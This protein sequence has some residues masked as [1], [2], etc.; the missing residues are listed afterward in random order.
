MRPVLVDDQVALLEDDGSEIF[1]HTFVEDGLLTPAE[2]PAPRSVMTEI[3]TGGG[4]IEYR[5]VY[6]G[7]VSASDNEEKE[8]LAF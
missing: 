1:T 5:D 6:G 3:L 7:V 8:A 2:V 4:T